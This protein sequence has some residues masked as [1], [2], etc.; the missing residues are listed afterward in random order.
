M[1]RRTLLLL[2][3]AAAV[4]LLYAGDQIYRAG[5][6]QPIDR[7]NNRL[8]G[9]VTREKKIKTTALEARRDQKRLDVYAALSLPYQPEQARAAYQQWLLALV[10]RHQMTQASVD[11]VQ[12]RTIEVRNRTRRGSRAVATRYPFQLRART[13]LTRLTAFLEEFSQAGH[14]HKITAMTL[15]PSGSDLDVSLSIE[16]LSIDACERESSL[17]TQTW[18][19]ASDPEAQWGVIARR[20]LFA[21]GFSQALTQTRLSGITYGADGEAEAW[22]QVGATQATRQVR[23]GEQLDI[24]LFLVDVIDIL[25]DRAFVRIDDQAGWLPVGSSLGDLIANPAPNP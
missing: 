12:P 11:P 3:G 2:L 24:E 22:F 20:N 4:G 13:N 14:L 7:L 19:R 17:S 10:D 23:A 6:E 21:R 1:N 15:N 8:D 5:Y 25:P 9:L 18:N 16:A